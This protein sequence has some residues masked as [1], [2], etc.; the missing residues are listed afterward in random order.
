MTPLL[1]FIN[2]AL[3]AFFPGVI[4]GI[5]FSNRFRKDSANTKGGSGR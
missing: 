3:L 4:A 2:G 1:A 5:L